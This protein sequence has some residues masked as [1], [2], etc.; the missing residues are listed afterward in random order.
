MN[1]L[2]SILLGLLI[3]G[4]ALVILGDDGDSGTKLAWLLVITFLPVIGL[5]LYVMFGINYRNHW[6]FN[7]RH[8][9]SIKA[10][11]E[12][13][14]PE[15]RE[16][17]F[18]HGQEGKVREDFRPLA[19]MIG[20]HE[21]PTVSE[22]NSFEIITHGQR[23]FDLLLRDIENAKE[24]V[25]VEYF[26]F[27]NDDSSVRIKELL[28]K[29]ASEGV[30]VRFLFENIANFP[31]SSHYYTNMKKAGVEVERFTNPRPHLLN[32][33][34]SI[35]YRDHRKIVIIDGRIAYTGGMNINNHYFHEWRD[36]HL[37]IEGNAVASLQYLFVDAWLTAGG[38]FDRPLMDY[39]PT[40]KENSPEVPSRTISEETLSNIK[41]DSAH[42]V[43]KGKLLQILPDEP[44]GNWP[45]IQY[46]YEWLFHNAKEYVW[47]QTPY[48]AP[49]V[50]IL[51]AIKAAA[52]RGVDVR[53]MVPE[54]PDNFLLRP[55][56]RSYFTECMEAGARFFLRGERFIHAK[57]IVADDYLSSVGTANL[58]QRSLSINYEVNTYI[59]D[60]E[61]ADV[62]KAIFRKD[63]E[64]CEELDL[65]AWARRPWYSKLVERIFRLFAPLL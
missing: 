47:I 1:L 52:L 44:D 22:G 50:A 8:A 10:W 59:Y 3:F 65:A 6:I 12:G 5:L 7:K 40:V 30:K 42:P 61:T 32:L 34:T 46:S 15:L 4:A 54:R 45:S 48:F 31:I 53:I 27:G 55:T 11:E 36:S 25:H 38:N 35:N 51:D 2:L 56:N 18:G 29:K 28:M 49:T 58:D 60:E 63:M 20:T 24:Y 14:G 21:S 9:R 41:L 43:L 39:F 19:Q 64:V 23:K 26:H 33:I 13:A 62:C 57:T 17:L 37:R 16:T